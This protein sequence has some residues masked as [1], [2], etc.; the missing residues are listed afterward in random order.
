MNN[1]I[2]VLVLAVAAALL[3]CSFSAK[4]FALTKGF[5]AISLSPA[6]DGGP[7]IGIWGSRNL[8]QWKWEAGTLAVYAYRPFQLTQNGNRARSI[9]DNTIVQ[10]FYGHVGLIDQWLS[11]GF[12][13][14][15]GWWADFKD[16][17]VATATN[18][19]KVVVG[20]IN[21]NLK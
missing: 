1:R 16:P 18:Q 11:I 6:T 21:I 13:L 20:D 15:M 12:D 8:D 7:Y 4:S 17:N 14:P 10:H 19:N 3:L 5:Q 2:N 9:L